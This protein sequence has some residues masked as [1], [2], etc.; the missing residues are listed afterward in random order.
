MGATATEGQGVRVNRGFLFWGL[1]FLSAGVSALAIQQGLVSRDVIAGAWR[2]WPLILIALG[3]A[4]IASRTPFAFLGTALAAALIGGVAGAAIAYGP[5][6]AISCAGNAASGGGLASQTGTFGQSATLDWHQDCGSLEVS[7]ADGSTWTA[8]VGN[9]GGQ[10]P[11][12]DVKADSLDIH[13]EDGSSFLDRGS[14]RWQVSLPKQTT[15]DADVETNGGK[16]TLNLAGAHFSRLRIHPNAGAVHVDLSDASVEDLDVQLN[17]G[18]LDISATS[19]TALQGE[20]ET[21][22]GE[23]NL[24]VPADAALRI[25]ASGT[26]F[27][28]NLDGANLRRSDDTWESPSYAGAQTTITITVHGNAGS[29]NLNPPGGC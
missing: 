15:Y 18:S 10:P 26:A 20:V 27:G 14:D 2:L 3:I 28:T 8:A 9:E 24:C 17:A 5:G 29:F 7:M 11:S 21:N 25:T 1:A 23:V 22:A 13:S 19:G 6:L 16:A 12:V 4:L